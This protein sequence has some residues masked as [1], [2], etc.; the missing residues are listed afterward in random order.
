MIVR[1]YII[2]ETTKEQLATL[3]TELFG[4]NYDFI[5]Q[6]RD[7][8]YVFRKDFPGYSFELPCKTSSSKS[9]WAGYRNSETSSW[10]DIG[11][12][13]ND[14]IKIRFYKEEG[15]YIY[16]TGITSDNKEHY[17]GGWIENSSCF[18]WTEYI[19][20]DYDVSNKL[21]FSPII[22]DNYLSLAPFFN[23]YEKNANPNYENIYIS[24]IRPSLDGS[25]TT[26]IINGKKYIT[27][28][29]NIF[30]KLKE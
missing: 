16:V 23:P 12:A 30:I 21:S 18:I 6:G 4:E 22:A 25:Y 11:A 27:M 15:Q 29:K 19:Y 7:W 9:L 5:V 28:S 2:A 3:I 26:F 20:Y 13:S 10:S 17:A 8:T 1:E 24:A 14:N